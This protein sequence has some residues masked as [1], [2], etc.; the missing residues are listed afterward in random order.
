[1]GRSTRID[2]EARNALVNWRACSLINAARQMVSFIVG[3]NCDHWVVAIQEIPL[4]AFAD[5]TDSPWGRRITPS[6]TAGVL[7]LARMHKPIK[8]KLDRDVTVYRGVSG[9]E[10]GLL[11]PAEWVNHPTLPLSKCVTMI[12]NCRTVIIAYSR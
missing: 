2:I 1:M 10:L 11:V 4:V 7:E 9:E 3:A 8:G 6:S 5:Q 12:D